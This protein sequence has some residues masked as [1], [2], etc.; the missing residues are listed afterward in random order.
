[1]SRLLPVSFACALLASA[2]LPAEASNSCM[3]RFRQTNL[4]TG[5]NPQTIVT[6]DFNRD[7]RLDFA[8][9][10]YNGGSSGFVSVFLGNGDGTFQPKADYAAGAG[11]DALGAGDVNG[12]GILDLVTGNDTGESVSVLIGKGDGTFQ[13]KQNY[14]VGLY[15]HGVVLA[16]FNGD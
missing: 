15:P 6:G 8:L 9:V 4:S 11:P 13:A 7:G 1:M 14:T 3:I 2:A 16:D 5:T 12:D 10:D